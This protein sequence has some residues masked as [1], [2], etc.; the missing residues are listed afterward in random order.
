M[1]EKPAYIITYFWCCFEQTNYG[2]RVCSPFA[3]PRKVDEEK[4]K[5]FNFKPNEKVFESSQREHE[6]RKS[7]GNKVENKEQS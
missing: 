3:F 2:F 6:R 4:K 5:K 1:K 7:S